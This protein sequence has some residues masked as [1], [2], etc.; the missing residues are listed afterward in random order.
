LQSL[1][2]QFHVQSVTLWLLDI[3]PIA[4]GQMTFSLTAIEIMV[5]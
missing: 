4:F 3:R 2:G 1:F 5:I